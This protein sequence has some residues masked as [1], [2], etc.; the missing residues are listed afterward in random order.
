MY[1]LRYTPQA[2][3][4]LDLVW[5]E[6]YKASKSFDIT[7]KYIND[8]VHAISNKKQFPKSGTPLQYNGLFT[9]FYFITFKK[10]MAFYRIKDNY[11]EVIRVL[12]GKRDYLQILFPD[13]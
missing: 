13:N 11:I 8:L 7:D 10:Y 4:D 1:L 3:K 2:L 9:G 12:Y 5:D 6:V